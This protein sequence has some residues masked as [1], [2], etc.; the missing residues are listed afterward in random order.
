MGPTPHHQ[1]GRHSSLKARFET[2][3]FCGARGISL[4]EADLEQDAVE[5]RE[6]FEFM[7]ETSSDVINGSFYR[8]FYRENEV[9]WQLSSEDKKTVYVGYYHILSAPNLPFKQARLKGLDAT[10]EYRVKNQRQS[11]YTGAALMQSGLALPWVDELQYN[12]AEDYM[13]RGDFST[14]IIVLEKL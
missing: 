4:S 7:K 2:G 8:I 10:A 14:C 13:D 5:I 3:F 1:N 9:C 6:H 11:R 12:S